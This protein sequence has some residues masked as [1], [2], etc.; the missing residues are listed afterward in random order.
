[1]NNIEDIASGASIKLEITKDNATADGKAINVAKV[2]V[3]QNNMKLNNWGVRFI[4]SQGSAT[5]FKNGLKTLDAKTSQGVATAEFT[6]SEVEIGEIKVVET[7]NDL[8][9]PI[10]NPHLD[11][12]PYHF[13][14]N[15]ELEYNL[16]MKKIT[17]N[18][19]ADGI[20]QDVASV[21]IT[22]THGRPPDAGLFTIK[23]TSSSNTTKFDT[24][25]K[26][27][28]SGSTKSTL[29]VSPTMNSAGELEALAYFSDTAE[30]GAVTITSSI[31]NNAKTIPQHVEFSFKNDTWG[32]GAGKGVD[33]CPADDHSLA[34]I[35]VTLTLNG[36]FVPDD[37]N[38]IIQLEIED[39]GAHFSMDGSLPG[40][41]QSKY[42]VKAKKVDNYNR[43]YIF[44]S[45]NKP[46]LININVSIPS[47]KAINPQK[48][49]YTFDE[50]KTI[51]LT[52]DRD[53]APAGLESDL[54]LATITE[55]G[56]ALLTGKEVICF[57]NRGNDNIVFDLEASDIDQKRSSKQCV[58]VN[59]HLNSQG[60][61]CAFASFSSKIPG[62]Y[63]ISARIDGY[64]GKSGFGT[65][66]FNFVYVDSNH[67]YFDN[68]IFRSTEKA[69]AICRVRDNLGQPVV[70]KSIQFE[71]PDNNFYFDKYQRQINVDTNEDGIATTQITGFVT[72]VDLD[73]T[74][75]MR[76]D[77]KSFSN[78]LYYHNSSPFMISIG[79]PFYDNDEW[80]CYLTRFPPGPSFT[81]VTLSIL[82]DKLDPDEDIYF[83][84]NDSN[85][86][87]V[88]VYSSWD[89]TVRLRSRKNKT[90]RLFASFNNGYVDQYRSVAIVFNN[91]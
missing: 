69:T 55:F 39:T 47:I 35:D 23:F 21:V 25:Q 8:N 11:S 90:A 91:C 86:K 36:Q 80:C 34:R 15:G 51:N 48:L 4:I 41:T 13:V 37:R 71:I 27:V 56:D 24:G 19:A 6:D 50:A 63:N 54:I 45:S 77:G 44:L 83:I 82:D 59:T 76:Y 9:Q 74:V 46:G 60:A 72:E 57:D 67:F 88:N 40:S 78:T 79:D 75:T 2:T 26:N 32:L 3:T 66:D 29:Y 64:Y 70:K 68:N 22:D 58:Y 61:P 87:I 7:T 10:T 73:T 43:C 30:E 81:S 85:T 38:P 12:K 28:I 89:Y 20:A 84:D 5:F 31:T 1:M 62:T 65:K 18:V 53:N 14:S 52:I 42:L 33:H 17:D 16:S 49:Q